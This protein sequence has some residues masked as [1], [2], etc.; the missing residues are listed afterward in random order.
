M[1]KLFALILAV[2]MICAMSTSV[3][4]ADRVIGGSDGV[5]TFP[6][7]GQGT[8]V[9]IT[10]DVGDTQH[11]YAIDITFEVMSFEVVGSNLTWDV[12]QLTYVSTGNTALE[13]ESFDVL[14]ENRS[15]LPIWYKATVADADL[16]D[17]VEVFVSHSTAASNTVIETTGVEVAKVTPGA[18]TT[19]NTFQINVSAGTVTDRVIT[20]AGTTAQWNDVCEYYADKL[21]AEGATSKA[22]ATVTVTFSMNAFSV[23]P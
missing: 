9:A 15:D 21:S 18:G 3:F 7:D 14:V 8:N 13:D 4:A 1:K 19:K 20:A 17:G 12:N 5:E 11:R 6:A 10:A 2:V 16:N 22:M 23:T